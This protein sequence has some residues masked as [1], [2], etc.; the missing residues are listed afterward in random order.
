[1]GMHMACIDEM[2]A[3][4][5]IDRHSICHIDATWMM[6]FMCERERELIPVESGGNGLLIGPDT[7][8]GHGPAFGCWIMALEWCMATVVII[9]DAVMASRTDAPHLQ[10][11]LF[12]NQTQLSIR[13]VLHTYIHTYLLTYL[14]TY[15][16]IHPTYIYPSMNTAYT[17]SM[18]Q[19][20]HMHQS[21]HMSSH[22]SQ[23]AHS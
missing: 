22:R 3:H 13:A 8:T 10:L 20:M 4:I 5:C 18:D 14:L 11:H 15:T 21:I 7:S 16:H 2:A 1:M 19:S 17:E 9:I 12:L 23:P 6:H